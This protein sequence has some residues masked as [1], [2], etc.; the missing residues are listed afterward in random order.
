MLL[1]LSA[2][3]SAACATLRIDVRGNVEEERNML[4]KADRRRLK[5]IFVVIEGAGGSG[6]MSKTG[7]RG[8]LHVG[9]ALLHRE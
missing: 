7:N 5:N 9:Q 6:K 8:S 3:T 2:E 4:H 1:L